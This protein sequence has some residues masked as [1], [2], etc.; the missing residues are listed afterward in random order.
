MRKTVQEKGIADSLGKVPPLA[1]LT[2][3]LC[4]KLGSIMCRSEAELQPGSPETEE[5]QPVFHYIRLLRE[6]KI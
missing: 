4:P 6:G 2:Q 5:A 1:A 3:S